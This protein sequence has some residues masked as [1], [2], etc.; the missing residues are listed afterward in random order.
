MRFPA[1]AASTCACRR[2]S[3]AT[4]LYPYSCFEQRASVA[5]G[6]RAEGLWAKVMLVLPEYLDGDGLIKF[7][8]VLRYGDDS[9]SA[10]ILSIADEA[11]WPIPDEQRA[12]IEQGLVG[13]V[14]GR[15]VRYSALPTADLSIRK[16]AALEA[17][18]RRKQ[19]FDPRWLDSI[20]IEPNLWPTS[21]VI[22]WYLVLKREPKLA[23]RDERMRE[24]EQIL[25]S[26]LNFQGTTMG[27]STEK[28]DALWWLMISGDR[29]ANRL[30]LALMDAPAWRE[31]VP[32]MVRGALG[33]MQDG[34]W[35]TTVANAWGVLA[36]EKFSAAFE[37]VAPTGTT[38]ATLASERF[39]HTWQPDDGAKFFERRLPWP[40][41][42]EDVSL[43]QDGEGKPWVTLQSIAAIPLREPFSS[44]Y[45]VAR[46]VTPVQQRVKGRWS[47]G[48]VARVHLEI[49]AQ[50]DMAWVVVDDPIPAG[51]TALG[52][53]LGGDSALLAQGEKKQGAVW[54]AYEERSFEA[55]RAYYTY[56]PKGK[57][58]VEYTVRLNNAGSFHLPATH[59]EAM[60]APEMLGEYP[61]ADWVVSP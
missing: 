4:S 20:A 56:V 58:V 14:E 46:E 59:V 50:S 55:F 49:E 12:R 17:L 53:G 16:M 51:S 29:N 43:R 57:F 54:P 35:N 47:Q 41:G 3:P 34:H 60:Y 36:L 32:R 25:R 27:F 6:L 13:F 42:R 15:V 24:A 2:S 61:I 19:G 22:D 5:V 7:W 44:G 33:R 37:S 48:D 21:A 18:S 38:T 1:A 39:A 8:P 31:D 10:Y 23:K 11:G 28:A 26:R 40:Q 9:L 45:K 30:I 52:R